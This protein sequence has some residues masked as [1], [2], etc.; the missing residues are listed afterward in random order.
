MNTSF[1]IAMLLGLA[2]ASGTIDT[3]GTKT[4]VKGVGSYD[5]FEGLC[6]DVGTDTTGDGSATL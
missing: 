6:Y 1:T 3:E 5:A 2:A 4:K